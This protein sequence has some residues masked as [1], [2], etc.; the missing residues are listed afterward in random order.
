[1]TA[2]EAYEY[3]ILTFLAVG[4]ACI[5]AH[6]LSQF[7]TTKI[8]YWF[9]IRRTKRRHPPHIWRAYK[10]YLDNLPRG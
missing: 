7:I 8:V 2:F 5:Q 10:A 6:F 4:V 3:L 9:L 1:M